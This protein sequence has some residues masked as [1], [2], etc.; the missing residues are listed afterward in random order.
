MRERA[1]VRACVKTYASA[2]VYAR[3]SIVVCLRACVIGTLTCVCTFAEHVF[4]FQRWYGSH[5][6]AQLTLLLHSLPFVA[7]GMRLHLDEPGK[8]GLCC[9]ECVCV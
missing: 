4:L 6:T 7:P 2:H 3:S 5:Y 8:D 1:R 9:G